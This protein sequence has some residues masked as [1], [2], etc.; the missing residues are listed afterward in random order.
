MDTSTLAYGFS[1]KSRGWGLLGL[2][3]YFD[4]TQFTVYD[5][6][7][8]NPKNPSVVEKLDLQ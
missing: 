1:T 6:V 7:T 4:S 2:I 8:H 3:T 5:G